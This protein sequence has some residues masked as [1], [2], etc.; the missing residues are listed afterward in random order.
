MLPES[1]D[2]ANYSILKEYSHF[3]NQIY[4]ERVS[5]GARNQINRRRGRGGSIY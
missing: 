3:V 1:F 2:L 4:S 5:F